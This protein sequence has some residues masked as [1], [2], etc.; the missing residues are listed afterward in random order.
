MMKSQ[1]YDS[2]LMN[3]WRLQSTAGDNDLTETGKL[4][5]LNG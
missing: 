1:P 5:Y 3:L 2:R 4:E